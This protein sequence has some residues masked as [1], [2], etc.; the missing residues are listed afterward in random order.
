VS[1]T[2][3]ENEVERALALAY[4]YLNRR[5]RTAAEMRAHLT[6]K[7][8]AEPELEASLTTLLDQGYLDDARFARLLAEDKRELEG[9]GAGRI[10]RTLAGRGI[11]RELIDEALGAAPPADELDRALALLR[12]RFP[13]PPAGRAARERALAVLLRKGYDSELALDALAQH[14]RD[15]DGESFR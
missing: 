4:R 14:A 15:P 10:R 13:V 9:W 8:V 5:E 11:D 3:A 6:A 12:R 2:D 7:G 1:A